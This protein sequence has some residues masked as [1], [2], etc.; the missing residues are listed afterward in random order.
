MIL[1]AMVGGSAFN[2]RIIRENRREWKIHGVVELHCF[3]EVMEDAGVSLLNGVT[4]VS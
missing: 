2:C 3:F 4:Q 1:R